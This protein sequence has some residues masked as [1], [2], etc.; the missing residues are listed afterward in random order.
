MIQHIRNLISDS[1]NLFD[2]SPD[3]AVI[4]AATSK[5]GHIDDD[6]L[7]LTKELAILR[8]DLRNELGKLS[9][10]I[11]EVDGVVG[12]LKLLISRKEEN[13]RNLRTKIN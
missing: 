10:I 12:E 7:K 11:E 8:A 9:G 2:S 3:F 1:Y 6:F 4:R 13:L 5:M